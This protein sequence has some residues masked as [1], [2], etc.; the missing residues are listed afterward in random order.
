MKKGSI[1][2]LKEDF[3]SDDEE[4]RMLSGMGYPLLLHNTPY[5]VSADAIDYTC[6]YCGK[7]HPAI[8][9]EEFPDLTFNGDHFYEVVSP[10]EV[11]VEALLEA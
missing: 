8:E 6:P 10:E 7:V 3:Y 9:L 11:M 5:Q 2:Q 1:V 4:M